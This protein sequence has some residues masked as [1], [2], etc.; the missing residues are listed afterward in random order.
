MLRPALAVFALAAVGAA[1]ASSPG[2]AVLDSVRK[3]VGVERS[4]PALFS[5]PAGGRLLASSSTGAWVIAQDGSIRRLGD[6]EDASWSPFG[7]FV[8]AS[9]ANELVALTPGGTIR[10][11]L[12]RLHPRLARWGGT[13][14]DTRIAY[15]SG[16]RLHVVAGDGTGDIE[17]GGLPA[18][19]PIAPAWQPGAARLLAYATTGGRV[20]L[21]N[22]DAD[23]SSGARP[24][25]QTRA[26][27]SGHRTGN[28]FSLSPATGSSCSPPT[29]RP[30][31][32]SGQPKV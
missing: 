1:L 21:Y 12:A 16:R 9:R 4:K 13:L 32:P 7:H 19:A 24:L 20:Y 18:A 22:P 27:C 25:T 6:F 11:K 31:P 8:V 30:R 3:A 14:T 29:A 10:W 2:Q 15:L 23:P 17:A 26:S 5:L 28:T